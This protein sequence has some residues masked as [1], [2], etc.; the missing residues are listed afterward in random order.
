VPGITFSGST[1]LVDKNARTADYARFAAALGY[2]ELKKL[3]AAGIRY[4]VS[5][6]GA[7]VSGGQLVMNSDLPG[8][9]LEY[10]TNGNIFIPYTGVTSSNAVVAVRARSADGSRAGRADSVD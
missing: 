7:N 9:P 10:S 8:L 5:V 6:P 1:N 2:K 4:R 3:D